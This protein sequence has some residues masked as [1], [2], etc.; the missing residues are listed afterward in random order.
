MSDSVDR[1]FVHALNTVKKI[2]RSG[3]ARPPPAD[4]LKL[5]GLYKQSMDML[6]QHRFWVRRDARELV[7]ELEFIWDQIKS[8]V[9]SS[10]ASSP[11]Q[12][13][14]V[15]SQG[16]PTYQS[17]SG[18]KETP[19]NVLS[20]VSEPPEIDDEG[21]HVEFDDALCDI[22]EGDDDR[23]KP[24]SPSHKR[25]EVQRN[26][27][28]RRRVEQAL[29]KMTAEVAALR[30]QIETRKAHKA[31]KRRSPWAWVVWIFWKAVKHIIFD[32]VL[33]GLLLLWM[34]R[35]RDRRLEQAVKTVFRVVRENLRRVQK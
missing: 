30:E 13:H 11:L 6:L 27:K 3:S 1:V 7:S 29:T 20:P 22:N 4:R 28:W 25:S 31:R 14:S 26:H 12:P 9:P 2:P 32:A 23:M 16:P 33:L 8:N 5:Y 15:P 34:R 10:A 18:D 19:L 21:E 35:R 24:G 17:T